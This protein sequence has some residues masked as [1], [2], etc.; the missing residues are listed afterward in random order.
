MPA[1]RHT[2]SPHASKEP[3][4]RRYQTRSRTTS[5]RSPASNAP[6]ALTR[7]RAASLDHTDAAPSHGSERVTRLVSLATHKFIAD[8]SNDALQHCKK[9][10][11]D[12]QGPAKPGRTERLVLTTEDLTASCK[13]FGIYIRKPSYYAD[14]PAAPGE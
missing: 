5:L 14:H 12:R 11:Q 6:S 7:H 3:R 2:H 4:A 8:L 9:R 10:Q 1:L 13:D